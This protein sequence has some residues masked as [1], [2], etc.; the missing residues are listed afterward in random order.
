MHDMID[1]LEGKSLRPAVCGAGFR[2]KCEGNDCFVVDYD[3]HTIVHLN[4]K[5]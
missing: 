4:P 3:T 2:L 5:N 1:H